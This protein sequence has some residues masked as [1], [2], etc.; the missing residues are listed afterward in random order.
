MKR[1]KVF[2]SRSRRVSTIRNPLAAVVAGQIER[3][4]ALRGMTQDEFILPASVLAAQEVLL[5]RVA[6]SANRRQMKALETILSR[7]LAQNQA[8]GLLLRTTSI[9]ER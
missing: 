9:W 7:P 5:D 3:A 1:A 2:A 4:A 8:V 6:L